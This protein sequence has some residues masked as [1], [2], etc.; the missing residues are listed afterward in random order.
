MVFIYEM[1]R[2]ILFVT[3]YGFIKLF[4]F[5]AVKFSIASMEVVL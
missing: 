3:L 5:V 2:I 1:D 4:I